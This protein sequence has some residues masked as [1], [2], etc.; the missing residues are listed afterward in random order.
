MEEHGNK[1]APVNGGDGPEPITAADVALLVNGRLVG[2]GSVLLSG[3]APLDRATARDLSFL[4]H[5]RYGHWFSNSKAGAVILAPQFENL[6]GAPTTRIVVEKPVEAMVSLLS[7]YHRVEPRPVGVHPT[8]VIADDVKLGKGVSIDANAVIGPDVVIGDGCWIGANTTVGA[9]TRI[10]RDVRLHPTSAID[11][12]SELGDRV[13][14]HSGA[15]IGREGFGFVPQGGVPVRIPHIGRC[16][17]ENDVEV[18]AN[19]CVDRGSVDDTIIGAGTKIDNLVQVGHNVRVGRMC[20]LAAQVGVAG[21]TRIEDGVQLGGQVGLS[22]HL[23]IGAGATLAAQ[24]G[25]F[26][27]VPAGEVWSGYPAR[28]H[29]EQLR[30]QAAVNRLTRLIRPLEQLL[31]GAKEP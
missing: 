15:R 2:D 13:V 7:R 10:G 4:S 24:A 1:G 11:P 14:V 23:T 17:L 28:P 6:E 18:G 29:K 16:V 25:V 27:D 3:I 19:S 8:A 22:G 26:G 5:L 30:A 31:R 12:F 20:F 21:S 9:G